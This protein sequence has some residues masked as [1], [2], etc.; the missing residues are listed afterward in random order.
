MPSIIHVRHS[1]S[2]SALFYTPALQFLFSLGGG[3]LK[4]AVLL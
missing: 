4:T 1:E 3:I 2:F